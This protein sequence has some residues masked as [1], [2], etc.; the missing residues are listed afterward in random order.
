MKKFKIKATLGITPSV[1]L[2]YKEASRFI[3][4]GASELFQLDIMEKAYT[5]DQIEQVTFVFKQPSG[6]ILAYDMFETFGDPASIN[7]SFSHVFGP[8]YNYIALNLK[9]SETAKFEPTK[10]GSV[11]LYEIAISIDGDDELENQIYTIVESQPNIAVI[12]SAYGEYIG[13]H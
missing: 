3:T 1:A 5:Y 7:D 8:D 10:Q 4:R 9:S 6:K 2:N 12:D 13:D 11:V